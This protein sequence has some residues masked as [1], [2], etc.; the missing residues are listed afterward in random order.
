MSRARLL[1]PATLGY[2]RA[3]SLGSQWQSHP[4][5]LPVACARASNAPDTL[6][7]LDAGFEELNQL[8]RGRGTALPSDPS[9]RENAA[10]I[11]HERRQMVV[12]SQPGTLVTSDSVQRL[13]A[14]L[15]AVPGTACTFPLKRIRELAGAALPE[16]ARSPA[17]WTDEAG[18]PACPASEACNSAGWRLE[19]VHAV[20]GLVR[21]THSRDESA[22][23]ETGDASDTPRHAGRRTTGGLGRLRRKPR[24]DR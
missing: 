19:S 20:A 23:R 11:D 3:G 2:R 18:W 12:P 7:L 8:R 9:L 14:Y 5:A 17:W 4:G 24:T 6:V 21:F 13:V 22:G 16:A 15:A 10:S 1:V